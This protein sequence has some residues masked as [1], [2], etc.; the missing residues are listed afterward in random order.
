L[1]SFEQSKYCLHDV[2]CRGQEY[3]KN[4]ANY[5]TLFR[6]IAGYACRTI[7]K[8]ANATTFG[9]SQAKTN[10]LSSK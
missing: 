6:S 5:L 4:L 10:Q 7:D 9:N 3:V 8:E 1:T 2:V